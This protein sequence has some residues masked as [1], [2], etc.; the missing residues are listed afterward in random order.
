MPNGPQAESPAARP[1]FRALVAHPEVQLVYVTGRHRELVEEAI[2]AYQLPYPDF[3]IG[4]VGTSIFSVQSHD[5]NLWPAWHDVLADDWGTTDGPAMLA[6]F[7]DEQNLTPQENAKQGRF[8]CSFYAPVSVDTN[9]LQQRMQA[10]L[11]QENLAAHIVWSIDDNRQLGLIDILPQRAS[12]LHA[13][14]FLMQQTDFD[15]DTTLFAGDSGNDLQVLISDIPAVL[16]ANATDSI[17]TEAQNLCKAAGTENAFYAA[18]GGF[19]G[20]NGNY[21]AGLLEGLVHFM[22]ETEA[23]ITAEGAQ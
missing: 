10:H 6:L 7:A 4:D 8:K 11:N 2:D 13:L 14:R 5:W 17:R 19:H 22:P 3:V 12:K 16:V 15:L 20:M 9:A 23:W 18:K 1:L 21:S